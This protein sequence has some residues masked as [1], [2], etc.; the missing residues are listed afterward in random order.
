[1][2]YCQ[3][4]ELFDRINRYGPMLEKDAASVFHQILSA[5]LYLKQQKISHRDIK[6]ENIMFHRNEK[7][8]IIDFGFSVS[9]KDDPFR[10]TTCGT[11]SYVAPE[12]LKHQ[13]YDPELVD[14]W[15]LGV[16]LYAMLAA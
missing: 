14:V 16:T 6:P 5:L 9:I 10:K 4:G 12:I 7:I 8:K 15:C 13:S 3:Q 2:E 11:P 1:M